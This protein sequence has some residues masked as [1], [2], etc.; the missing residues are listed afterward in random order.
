MLRAYVF[1]FATLPVLAGQSDEI[2]TDQ[3]PRQLV[4]YYPT[5]RSS[6]LAARRV[7]RMSSNF[8]NCPSNLNGHSKTGDVIRAG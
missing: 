5:G 2:S 1:I 8:G 7:H 3:N 4:I 6:F